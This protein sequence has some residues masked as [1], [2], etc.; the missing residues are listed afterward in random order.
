MFVTKQITQILT[1]EGFDV[2][3]TAENGEDGYEK[4]KELHPNVDLVTMDI[5]MPK[6]DGVTSLQKIIEFD[7]DARVVMISALG[8][9]D[10]VK[11]SLMIGAKNYIVKPLDRKKV[12]ERISS[13][14]TPD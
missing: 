9:Q 12:L 7:K 1:S 6:M 11:Q 3:A 5:T 13:A 14:I 2:V 10:L 4:Y 8:K